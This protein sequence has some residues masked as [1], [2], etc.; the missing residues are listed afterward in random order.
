MRKTRTTRARAFGARGSA[1]QVVALGRRTPLPRRS[2]SLP[3]RSAVG[4]CLL[5]WRRSWSAASRSVAHPT[6][7]ETRTK[8]SN[9]CASLRVVRKT[10]RNLKGAMK[11]KVDRRLPFN[12]V[13][14]RCRPRRDPMDSEYLETRKAGSGKADLCGPSRSRAEGCGRSR[15]CPCQRGLAC[16]KEPRDPGRRTAGP[17]LPHRRWGGARAYTLG[18]ERWWTM[19]G[20]DEAR[21]NSG[22]GP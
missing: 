12:R 18:P 14:P 6:R 4:R 7:L 10:R 13:G 5:P 17:S 11:V 9:M 8:E 1:R 20:Q 19:L 22:G 15:A 21:G 3:T 16:D 2:V